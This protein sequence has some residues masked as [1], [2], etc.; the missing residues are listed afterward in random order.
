MHGC[1]PNDSICHVFGED[2]RLI[3]GKI[4]LELEMFDKFII[5]S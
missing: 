5:Y 2:L 1:S 3:L 4:V